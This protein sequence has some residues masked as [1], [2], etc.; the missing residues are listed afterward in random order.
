MGLFNFLFNHEMG[1]DSSPAIDKTPA[2]NCN[3]TPMMPSSNIDIEGKPYGVCTDDSMV[4]SSM[5][6]SME[7]MSNDFDDSF[8]SFEDDTSSSFDDNW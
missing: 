2:V 1:G 7:L 5:D 6:D 8:S 4:S 3:G